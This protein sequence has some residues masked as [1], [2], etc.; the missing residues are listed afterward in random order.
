MWRKLKVLAETWIFKNT[1]TMH[2][3]GKKKSQFSS[4]VKAVPFKRKKEHPSHRLGIMRSLPYEILSLLMG[5]LFVYLCIVYL[6]IQV[7]SFSSR[8]SMGEALRKMFK[9]KYFR[10]LSTRSSYFYSWQI[11]SIC[12]Y[13]WKDLLEVFLYINFFCWKKFNNIYKCILLTIFEFSLVILTH[14]RKFKSKK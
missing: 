6:T 7:H 12:E 1:F 11:A 13:L 3:L 8:T 2:L 14:Y 9:G 5:W 4:F 10:W